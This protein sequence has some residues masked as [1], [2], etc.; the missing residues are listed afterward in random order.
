MSDET[1]SRKLD[2]LNLCKKQDVEFKNKTAGFEKIELEYNALPEIDKRE[3]DMSIEFIGKKLNAPLIAAAITGG[4]PDVRD[5]N[6]EIA[7]ACQETGLG[8]GVGSQRE[9]IEDPEV[10]DTYQIRDVAPDILLLGNIGLA[11]AKEYDLEKIENALE[12]IDADALCI[13]INAAQEAVQPEGDVNFTDGYSTIKRIAKELDY[14]VIVKEVG[15]GISG[16]VAKSLSE[17]GIDGIDVGG[18]GGTSWTAVDS[19]RRKDSISETFWDW[20]IP[21]V[22]CILDAKDVF[23]GN[24]IATGGIRSGL[25]IAKSIA[26]G[27]N[28]CGCALP[29]MCAALDYKTKDL[30]EKLLEELRITM[31]L[32]GCKNVK[33]LSEA[34][35]S[36]R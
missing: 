2:H 22:D 32:T 16:R 13:H 31:F 18:A 25:D 3:I 33:E 11:Q 26:L 24:I 8:M 9:M 27:A 5:V 34:E 10:T 19:L 7:R 21:T 35:Y 6:L 20:G 4:H 1:K 17:T 23:D 30:F 28:L 36:I 12:A 29:V 14:R 15:N